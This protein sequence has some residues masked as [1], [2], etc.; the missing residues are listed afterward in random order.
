MCS[1]LALFNFFVNVLPHA[2]TEYNKQMRNLITWLSKR[3]FPYEPLITVEISKSRLLHN[4]NEFR[5]IAPC[6]VV[7]PVLKSNAYGH[8]L[9]EVAHIL[10][11]ESHIPFC[12]VD[13]YFEAVA[14]R[15][16][17]FKLPLMV[18]GYTRP[19]TILRSR[20][21]DTMFTVTS[22]DTLR[23][24]ENIERTVR[25]NLKIDTG[26]HRQG[27]VLEEIDTAVTM[28]ASN[29][30]IKL[31]S[32]C[33]HFSDADN[34]DSSWT[35]AQ[36]HIWNTAAKKLKSAFP[37]IKYTHLSN[38]DGHRFSKEIDANI[39]R[40]G[41]GM[42]GLVD[43]NS[44]TPRLDLKPILEIKTIVTGI[45]KLHVNDTVGYGN[46]FKAE[47][48]MVIATISAGYF[49]GI[50]RRLSNKGSLLLGHSEMACPIVGRVSMNITTIDVSHDSTVKIG[51]PVI[52]MSNDSSKPNSI[53]A[54]AK[55]CG[56]IPYDIAVHIAPSLK[57]VVV[58]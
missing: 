50:D 29:P 48:D 9:M 18:I 7:A 11:D 27:I 58:E 6:G 32:I 12:V 3:R 28:I 45:K 1:I 37:L 23:E 24:I 35:E 41:I 47:K 22:I 17:Q 40:L 57:R 44:F 49:E 36:I 31:E 26:M 20:L 13:S 51:K 25:I 19:E 55:L 43:G 2:L 52:I 42:Y 5:K 8:G 56:T 46:T 14:L 21:S 15:T 54:I 38:T 34:T 10:R 53:Q 4:L 39:S 30:F 33:S 16:K